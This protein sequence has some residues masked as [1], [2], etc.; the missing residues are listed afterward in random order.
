MVASNY[1]Y[2]QRSSLFQTNISHDRAEPVGA[3]VQMENGQWLP[4]AELNHGL[5]WSV[6]SGRAGGWK[7]STLK[8]IF[9]CKRLLESRTAAL[10]SS[11]NLLQSILRF[12]GENVP[13]LN[14]RL[15]CLLA[16]CQFWC[17]GE[18]VFKVPVCLPSQPN[19]HLS[20]RQ[21]QQ[22]SIFPPYFFGVSY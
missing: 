12:R 16:C 17:K 21:K 19:S 10:A 3:A 18:T 9:L 20:P 1:S 14:C 7:E 6:R 4:F 11:C 22:G 13:K 8:C 2:F 5:I 15:S